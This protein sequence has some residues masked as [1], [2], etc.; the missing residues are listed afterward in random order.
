VA[1]V[2]GFGVEHR[3]RRVGED[4]MVAQLC[5]ALRYVCLQGVSSCP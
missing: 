1:A 2:V 4:C 5:A 3:Q